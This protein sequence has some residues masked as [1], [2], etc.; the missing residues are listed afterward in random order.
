M[1]AL[2]PDIMVF[3]TWSRHYKIKTYVT[4]FACTVR[5]YSL[6]RLVQDRFK[7]ENLVIEMIGDIGVLARH[8]VAST[9]SAIAT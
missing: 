4:S 2:D 3:A 9:L 5:H 8:Q 6:M 7:N 1:D